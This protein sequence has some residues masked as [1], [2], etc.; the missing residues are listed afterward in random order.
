VQ[1]YL[2]ALERTGDGIADLPISA[3]SDGAPRGALI[4]GKAAL[5]FLAIRQEIGDDAF[6]TALRAWADEFAFRIAEPD[7]L[8]DA[9]E[10]ASGQ[11]IGELWRFWFL[12][13]ETTAADV[14]ALIDDV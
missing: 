13:A 9:F 11:Q 7:D 5:G 14:Q 3:E 8:L 2:R 10:A 1:P 12:A 6:F 4:Y